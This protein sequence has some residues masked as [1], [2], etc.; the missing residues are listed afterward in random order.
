[1]KLLSFDVGI[2]NLAYCLINTS[3]NKIEQWGIID[4]FA[5]LVHN[6]APVLCGNIKGRN[7]K[8]CDKPASICYTLTEKT[9][10]IWTANIC[11][12]C[13]K[14]LGTEF[15]QW[16]K[17]TI[18]GAKTTTKDYG[19]EEYGRAMKSALNELD[20]GVVDKIIIENQPVLKNPTMKSIQMM[21][22]SY[23]VF[24]YN[25]PIVLYS[26]RN[27][28]GIAGI[29]SVKVAGDNSGKK[30]Y[31]QRKTE[32]KTW[33]RD[34]LVSGDN[35]WL[36]YYDETAK[37]DDLADCLIQALSYADKHKSPTDI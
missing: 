20:F 32:A 26:A 22:F 1:M 12:A 34:W 25:T 28:L 27:K 33:V 6:N 30:A 21:L 4:L 13:D 9:E 15:S 7:H 36:E 35:K 14:K 37:K 11:S 29:K 10:N 23:F 8:T 16:T 17:R 31:A 24:N 19:L 5:I 2:K 3:T 18:K